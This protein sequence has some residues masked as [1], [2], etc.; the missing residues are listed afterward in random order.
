MN[1]SPAISD[2]LRE[3]ALL[4]QEFENT[5]LWQRKNVREGAIT[6]QQQ[7]QRFE[8]ATD[9]ATRA[10]AAVWAWEGYVL[11]S[12]ALPD[13]YLAAPDERKIG[14][15]T[16]HTIAKMFGGESAWLRRVHDA[17]PRA[18]QATIENAKARGIGND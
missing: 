1:R 14:W 6:I 13:T 12:S 4:A 7:A 2:V 17:W 3:A 16:A 9:D 15:A 11:L 5:P 18:S 8:R 10:D